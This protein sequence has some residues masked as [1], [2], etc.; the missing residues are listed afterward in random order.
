[1]GQITTGVRAILSHPKVYDAFQRLMGTQQLRRELA[2]EFIR[3]QNGNRVL[4]IGCG[5]AEILDFLPPVE[6]FGFDISQRYIKAARFRFGTRGHFFCQA[7]TSEVIDTLPKFDLVFTFGLLHHLDDTEATALLRMIH[8]VL[9]RGGRVVSFD[10][11]LDSGQSFVARFLVSHDRGQNVR[12]A[13]GYRALAESVFTDVQGVVH[14][15]HCMPYVP[16]TNWIME[17]MA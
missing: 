13:V 14:H 2:D 11:V 9:R 8:S 6:Y 17:C 15:R 4:D 1:M 16:Y 3:A 5:T 7:L 12:T 10:P